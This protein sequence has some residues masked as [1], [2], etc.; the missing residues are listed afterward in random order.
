MATTMA[1]AMQTQSKLAAFGGVM[2]YAA[3][4]GLMAMKGAQDFKSQTQAL[5]DSFGNGANLPAKMLEA[6]KDG[7]SKAASDIA[8][9]MRSYGTVSYQ[10]AHQGFQS[11]IEAAQSYQEMRGKYDDSFQ[12]KIS[13]TSA[14]T[15]A[16]QGMQAIKGMKDYLG[17]SQEDAINMV[18]KQAGRMTYAQTQTPAQDMKTKDGDFGSAGYEKVALIAGRKQSDEA[19]GAAK[20]ILHELKMHGDVGFKN[21]AQSSVE[22]Q[23]ESG[24]GSIRGAGGIHSLAWQSGVKAESDS[25]ALR[26]TIGRYGA[27]SY[28]GLNEFQ[29][30]KG[31]TSL[32]SEKESF[33]YKFGE[34]GYAG[35]KGMD[36]FELASYHNSLKQH[37]EMKGTAAGVAATG[38]DR[39]ESNAK[40]MTKA[41]ADATDAKIGVSGGFTGFVSSSVASARAQ[42]AALVSEIA[43]AG[44]EAAYIQNA[45]YGS[46]QKGQQAT[47]EREQDLSAKLAEVDNETGLTKTSSLG[48]RGLENEA[49]EKSVQKKKKATDREHQAENI[50]AALDSKSIDREKTL[51]AIGIDESALADGGKGMS[52]E[53][54]RMIKTNSEKKIDKAELNVVGIDGKTSSTTLRSMA[55]ENS[56]GSLNWTAQVENQSSV[57]KRERGQIVNLHSKDSLEAFGKEGALG[58]LGQVAV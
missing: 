10:G 5:S 7:G 22:S 32:K 12:A 25:N 23:T 9:A 29:A 16:E 56:D 20:G 52:A 30:V 26:G 6:M 18:A 58:V 21:V 35:A 57:E 28:I 51:K 17:G 1:S 45:A 42:Q 38:T 46:Y 24:L 31:I 50:E 34:Q 39:F 49:V 13:E 15:Q 14:K 2:P 48:A 8:N 41:N 54:Y 43:G 37:A 47:K 4:E 55:T 27:E 53:Q 44:T 36:G 33:D 11:Q 3:A 19:V 40:A